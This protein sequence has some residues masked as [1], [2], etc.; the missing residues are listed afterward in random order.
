VL[1]KGGSLAEIRPLG[2]DG[3]QNLLWESPW[4]G[5]DVSLTDAEIAERYGDVNSGRFLH[6]YTGHAL[7]LDGFGPASAKELAQ[8][9]GLHG[10][11]IRAEW[12]FERMS[13]E[14]FRAET[15]LPGA[16]LAVE[17]VYTLKRGEAI[18]RVQETLTNLGEASRNLHWV[19]HAT[20]GNPAFSEGARVVTSARQ[21]LTWPLDYEGKNALKVDAPFEWPLA[22][23]SAGKAVDLSALFTIPHSGFVA[24]LKQPAGRSLAFVAAQDLNA[25]VLLVYV[26]PASIFPWLTL[27]E[28]NQARDEAPW[29]GGVCARGLEFGTTPFPLG[30]E[31]VDAQGSVMGAPISR[32][33]APGKSITARW[34]VGAAQLPPDGGD[35]HDVVVEEEALVL[36]C[37]RGE[38]HVSAGGVAYFLTEESGR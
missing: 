6:H 35:L 34:L 13:D 24:A 25:R 4:F 20:V 19:Q 8:G 1:R 32:P 28:E 9:G 12:S 5:P 37:S 22:P 30:N 33:L 10:E 36:R 11:A 23:G 16:Q 31:A 3:Q 15:A 17:R 18:L 38:A 7:C 14:E 2:A 27:W 29:N 21:G 26:Y